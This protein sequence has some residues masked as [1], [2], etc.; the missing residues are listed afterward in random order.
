M[1]ERIHR[2]AGSKFDIEFVDA[3]RTAMLRFHPEFGN[4]LVVCLL[5]ESLE[6]IR[7]DAEFFIFRTDRDAA[8]FGT[9]VEPTGKRILFGLQSL[10]HHIR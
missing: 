2:D 3:G 6:F 7:F 10:N 1:F 4:A 8:Q 9:D 5:G